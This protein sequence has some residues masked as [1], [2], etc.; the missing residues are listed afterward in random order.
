MKWTKKGHIYRPRGEI[1][2]ARH[3]ALTPTPVLINEN[4][5][6]VYVGLRDQLGVSRIGFVDVAAE[7]P[8]K[9][10]SVSE[11]PA[12]DVG[13]AGAFDD[14]GVILGDIVENNG[15]YYMY[16]VGFQ[17]V[18]NVKF[19]AF[20]GLATSND[21]GTTYQR[22]SEVPI[23]DRSDGELYIRAIHTVQIEG[24]LWRIWYAS[25]NSWQLINGNPYPRYNIRYTELSDDT[26]RLRDSMVCVNTEKNE[27]RIGRPRVYKRGEGYIMLYTRGTLDGDYVAGYAESPDGKKWHRQ[28]HNL[29]IELS[30]SGWDS[31]ALC[32]PALIEVKDRVYMFYNGN[33][34]G[35]TGFGYAVLEQW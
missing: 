3:S 33:N 35:E 18:T 30:P 4:T 19:L 11:S 20:T 29:G 24:P 10:L 12:L 31:M 26:T 7:N 23:L 34:M 22:V 25:G 2:W 14:N 32:Y 13:I 9:I 28:D 6:R 17:L 1:P 16:Y 8:S 27:Y 5:I 21:G 15:L